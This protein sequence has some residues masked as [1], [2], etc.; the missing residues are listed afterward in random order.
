MKKWGVI[1][2]V[3]VLVLAGGAAAWYFLIAEEVLPLSPLDAAPA[4]PVYVIRMPSDASWWEQAEE[5]P[6]WTQLSRTGVVSDYE[7]GIAELLAIAGLDSVP[8]DLP[9]GW[10][11]AYITGAGKTDLLFTL[12]WKTEVPGGG[13]GEVFEGVTV[14]T[15]ESGFQYFAERGVLAGSSSRLIIEDAIRGL[16]SATALS[17]DNDFVLISQGK[18][19]DDPTLFVS[20][21][22]LTEYIGMFVGPDYASTLDGLSNV[23]NWMALDL[24]VYE[25]SVFL[26]G[27]SWADPNQVL[28]RFGIPDTAASVIESVIPGNTGFLW[29]TAGLPRGLMRQGREEDA[30]TTWLGGESGLAMTETLSEDPEAFMLYALSLSDPASATTA[31]ASVGTSAPAWKQFDVW[32]LN[33]SE[34][35]ISS[36]FGESLKLFDGAY[37]TV[38]GQFALFAPD[39]GALERAAEAW[40]NRQ[41]LASNEDYIRYRSQLSARANAYLYFDPS[42]LREVGSTLV[43]DKYGDSVQTMLSRFESLRPLTLQFDRYRDK[44]LTSG[45]IHYGQVR[46]S[47]PSG[48]LWTLA[49]DTALAIEPVFVRNHDSGET[50]ILVQD[51]ANNLYLVARDGKVLW[52]RQLDGPVTGPIHQIDYYK[53]R[54]LQYLFSTPGSV[55]LID[56]KGRNVADYPI[57]FSAGTTTGVACID[58]DSKRDY[59]IFVGG[60]NGNLYGYYK[61]GKPLPGWNP[62]RGTGVL[63][64]PVTH[65]ATGGKDYLVVSSSNGELRLLNRRG[66]RRIDPVNLGSPLISQI[67]ISSD[68]EMLSCDTLGRLLTIKVDGT[69]RSLQLPRVDG[70][71]VLLTADLHESEGKEHLIFNQETGSSMIELRAQDGTRLWDS[72]LP[73][74]EAFLSFVD[75]GSSSLIAVSSSDASE[76]NV[77]GSEGSLLPGFPLP[78]GGPV[79]IGELTGEGSQVLVGGKANL[80]VARRLN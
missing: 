42:R 19:N 17:Q 53:N 48:N 43:L 71:T 33:S 55:H 11:A 22:S 3:L 4:D 52:K 73:A 7:Q 80:L 59:R 77:F 2:T 14:R 79:A 38:L 45:F 67:R 49:L 68:D 24:R 70:E 41:G 60:N 57:N 65:F 61:T 30:W 76:W 26:N 10:A 75:E 9:T 28:G 56:R 5:Q 20:A 8:S 34:R 27:F 39:R 50:E 35:Q 23:L 47:A 16:G 15:T 13:S 6:M 66:E 36:R 74:G 29:R 51:A 78:G 18:R 63:T 12:P 72:R 58:Y 64:Q 37:V 69:Y 54:K 21:R 44:F 25:E 1:L 32:Q 62:L 46:R 31:L 40:Q